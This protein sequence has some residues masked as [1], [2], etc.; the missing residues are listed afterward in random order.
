MAMY[1]NL[2]N[3]NLSPPLFKCMRTAKRAGGTRLLESSRTMLGGYDV[4][5]ASN[6]YL[7]VL[8]YSRDS[9]LN[10]NDIKSTFY[11]IAFEF[12]V[13]CYQ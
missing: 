12:I 4:F 13:N 5:Y 10:K 11:C 9:Q 1:Y 2:L 3:V 8:V 7:F 6:V